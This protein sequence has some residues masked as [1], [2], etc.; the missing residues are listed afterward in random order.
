MAGRFL[1]YCGFMFNLDIL[2]FILVYIFFFAPFWKSILLSFVQPLQ[3]SCAYLSTYML[4]ISDR[5]GSIDLPASSSLLSSFALIA[6]LVVVAAMV[7]VVG[8]KSARISV[9][10][11][12]E[13]ITIW[14]PFGYC[15]VFFSLDLTDVDNSTGIGCYTNLI[16]WW[17]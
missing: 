9:G 17:L 3:I 5:F 6:Q 7:V 15:S 16:F 2:R 12:Q 13:E 11:W 14:A 8:I 1:G 4:D 10:R